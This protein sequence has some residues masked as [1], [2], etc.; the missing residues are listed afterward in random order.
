MSL[1]TFNAEASPRLFFNS[2][3]VNPAQKYEGTTQCRKRALNSK[4]RL[5]R[6]LLSPCTIIASRASTLWAK[7]SSRY[8]M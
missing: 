1:Y 2:G 4:Q 5:T 3:T 6:K 8:A 7:I